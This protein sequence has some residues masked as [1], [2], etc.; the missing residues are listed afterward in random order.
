MQTKVEARHDV[1]NTLKTVCDTVQT[2][3]ESKFAEVSHMSH[4]RHMVHMSHMLHMLHMV[5]MVHM[6]R[7]LHMSQ[8]I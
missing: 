4:M 1:W 5:H 8:N 6:S 3:R 2:W 7:I